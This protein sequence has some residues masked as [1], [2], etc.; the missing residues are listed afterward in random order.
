[1]GR[2]GK[3]KEIAD[4]ALFLASDK[5]SFVSRCAVCRWWTNSADIKE[6]IAHTVHVY[7]GTWGVDEM[8]SAGLH[9]T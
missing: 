3:A 8:T 5:A 6:E 9:F 2:L 4:V 7:H 1:M